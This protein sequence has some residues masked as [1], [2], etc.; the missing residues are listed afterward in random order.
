MFHDEGHG[1]DVFGMDPRAVARWAAVA[2]P[3]YDRYFRVESR[4]VEHVPAQG[5]AIVVANHSGVLPVD[6]AMLWLDLHRRTGRY[7]R[8]IADRFVP[9]LPFVGTT[10]ARAG[11][12]SGTR[13]NV[14][15]LL[16]R[17]ELLVIFPE[18]VGGV[19]KPWRE[20]Y[21]L[22]RWHLGHAE[23]AIAHAAPVI[24][25]AIVGAEE[26]WPVLVR[27]RWAR[28]FGAPYL[29][30]PMSPVPLPARY[31]VR[32][33]PPYRCADP[34]ES[35]DDPEVAA[36]AAARIRDAVEGLVAEALAARKGVWS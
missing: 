4:G 25:T 3:L 17:G 34:P 10:F 22:E 28:L 19:A 33:G 26:S 23:L 12:V 11:V 27:L 8:M 6:A 1:Y 2:A 5:P 18:G 14:A 31:H 29:P 16:D 9:G 13:T 30:V 24:P 21:H 15:R 35:A 36:E 20:R 7:P 32:Y